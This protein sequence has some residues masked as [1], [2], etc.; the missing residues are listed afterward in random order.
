M[1]TSVAC[2]AI[3]TD[4]LQALKGEPLN[5]VFLSDGTLISASAVHHCREIGEGLGGDES[6]GHQ[7]GGDGEQSWMQWVSA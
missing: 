1:A 2:V 6:C 5:S 3:Y 4:L 7:G